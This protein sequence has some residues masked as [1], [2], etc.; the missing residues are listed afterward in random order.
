MCNASH[1]HSIFCILP[2]DIL[3]RIAK[4]GN[5]EQREFAL[6]ALAIDSSFRSSRQEFSL[7]GGLKISHEAATTGPPAPQITIFDSKQT[8][9]LPGDIARTQ[10]QSPV[11]DVEVNEAYD[12]LDDTFQFYL[13]VY[14]RN[15]IDNQGLPLKASVHFDKNYDNAFWNGQ[16]MVFGDGDGIILIAS[17]S[18]WT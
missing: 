8:Q 4:N 18:H 14:Q 9:N 11:A 7:L 3:L 13:N 6:K 1:Q 17:P 10:G 15:S 5:Q 2:P 16:Q 12:G